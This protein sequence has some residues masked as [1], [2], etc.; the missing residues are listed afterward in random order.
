VSPPTTADITACKEE[1]TPFF[2]K[3]GNIMIRLWIAIALTTTLAIFLMVSKGSNTES[4]DHSITLMMTKPYQSGEW[5]FVHCT[6]TN[7][8]C[9]RLG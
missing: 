3:K 1:K 4:L 6:S 5:K 2:L 9:G 8:N 7:Q